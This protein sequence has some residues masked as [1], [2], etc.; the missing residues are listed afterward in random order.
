MLLET[1]ERPL[2]CLER[3]FCGGGRQLS[4]PEMGNQL[5]LALNN[6]PSFRNVT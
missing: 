4:A 5:A 6:A 1:G 3:F 2:K